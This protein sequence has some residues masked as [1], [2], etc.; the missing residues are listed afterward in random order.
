M[1]ERGQCFARMV[2]VGVRH[3]RV[4]AHHI[5]APDLALLDGMHDLDHG[6]AGLVVERAR[7]HAPSLFEALARGLVGHSLVV[8]V[9]HRD[10]ARVRCALHVVLSTQRM[11]PGAWPSDLASHQRQGDQ[12]SRVVG[13]VN[14]LRDTHA[15]KNHRGLGRGIETRDIANRLGIDTADRCHRLGAVA[16]DIP[17]QLVVADGAARD[18]LLVGQAL[19]DDDVHHRVKHRDIGVRLEL[20]EAVSDARKV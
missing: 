20:H 19:G 3:G 16:F 15:P 11:Q 14:V 8:R 12:A 6:Q 18:E 1:I 5:H 9:H 7:R 4:F 10:Q 17:A 2:R 13:P